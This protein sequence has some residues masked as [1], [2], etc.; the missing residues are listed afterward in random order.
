MFP[1]DTTLILW[2]SSFAISVVILFNVLMEAD[3]EKLK[4]IA[5]G[6]IIS[7]AKI[8]INI[9]VVVLYGGVINTIF[10]IWFINL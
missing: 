1:L 2:L 6:T 7:P 4:N 3:I 5:K 9:T 8:S 10:I